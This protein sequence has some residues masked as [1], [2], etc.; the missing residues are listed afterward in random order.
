MTGDMEM[1]H[2]TMEMQ[3]AYLPIAVQSPCPIVRSSA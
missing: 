3:L 2:G 1:E